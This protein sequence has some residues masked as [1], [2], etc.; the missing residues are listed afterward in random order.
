MTTQPTDGANGELVVDASPEFKKN[1][2]ALKK[3]YRSIGRDIAP[4]IKQIQSGQLPGEQI[5]GTGFI[6][7]KVRVKNRDIRKGKSAGYRLIYQLESELRIAL[8]T[9]Y[10][11]SDKSNVSAELLKEVISKMVESSG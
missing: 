9:I 6:V 3:R 1:L 7:Y 4:V 2:R 11:K 5:A 8:L 10:S